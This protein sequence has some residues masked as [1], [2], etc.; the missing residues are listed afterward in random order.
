[1]TQVTAEL[2]EEGGAAFIASFNRLLESIEGKRR[3]SLPKP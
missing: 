1:M 2:E 3:S